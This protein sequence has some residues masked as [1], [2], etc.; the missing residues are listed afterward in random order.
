[1]VVTQWYYFVAATQRKLETSKRTSAEGEH[2]LRW[3][4]TWRRGEK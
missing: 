4:L 1:V 3:R 2:F